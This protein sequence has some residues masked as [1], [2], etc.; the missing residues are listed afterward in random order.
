MNTEFRKAGL[1]K[2]F[3]LEKLDSFTSPKFTKKGINDLHSDLR[4]LRNILQ[5]HEFSE[6][7]LWN[8]KNEKHDKEELDIQTLEGEETEIIKSE[9][10]VEIRE[11]ELKLES[12]IIE[13]EDSH[14]T[15]KIEHAAEVTE[16]FVEELE[17]EIDSFDFD[18][19]PDI[20]VNSDS[21]ILE[22]H[23][24]FENEI[25]NHNNYTK[26]ADS[27]VRAVLDEYLEGEASARENVEK[28]RTLFGSI[29]KRNWSAPFKA[30]VATVMFEE[31]Y[32][33]R[34]DEIDDIQTYCD[35]ERNQVREFT[36]EPMR[37]LKYDPR[38]PYIQILISR[39][40]I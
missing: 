27:C 40:I 20:E 23:E 32:Q 3:K 19:I 37:F 29:N 7:L 33:R 39:S 25:I 2:Q 38:P 28:I 5:S 12:P 22:W 34:V 31:K 35:I 9:Q 18:E 8:E 17:T 24:E 6:I 15:E 11:T 14:E 16:D 26:S 4:W 1:L 10:E 13:S 30:L 36:K 21:E